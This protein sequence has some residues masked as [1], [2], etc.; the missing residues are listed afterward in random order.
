METKKCST[1]GCGVHP[2][3]RFNWLNKKKGRRTAKCK[4][5]ISEIYTRPKHSR[6]G[7]TTNILQTVD[8]QMSFTLLT[9][10]WLVN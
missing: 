2:V 10:K 9:K 3:D 8:F 6:T 7:P 1:E 4:R 5:C